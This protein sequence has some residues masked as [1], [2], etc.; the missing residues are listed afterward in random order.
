ML[1]CASLAEKNAKKTAINMAAGVA[2]LILAGLTLSTF[3]R[4]HT[5]RKMNVRV[6]LPWILLGISANLVVGVLWFDGTFS[7]FKPTT[8]WSLQLWMSLGGQLLSAGAI[9]ILLFFMAQAIH[10]ERPSNSEN[11]T[12][13]NINADFILGA[14]FAILLAGFYAVVS[15]LFPS[16]ETSP[17]YAAD[18]STYIPWLTAIFNG[19]KG[20]LK[21]TIMIILII[22]A[23]RF[24]QSRL[25]VILCAVLLMVLSVATALA[26]NEVGAALAKQCLFVFSLVLGIELIRRKQ[27]GVLIAMSGV[28]VAL[29]QAGIANALYASAWV[30]ALLS[31]NCCLLVTYALLRHWH[32]TGVT[33]SSDNLEIC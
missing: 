17:I 29:Q 32:R 7:G 5:G 28:G 30:H 18:W 23:V 20:F 11:K 22:G 19:L 4:K 12:G 6:A 31:A 10:A 27:L 16:T 21:I 13:A 1:N 25:K 8:S 33:V 24:L 3:F 15:L 2:V 26:A 9:G 14:G